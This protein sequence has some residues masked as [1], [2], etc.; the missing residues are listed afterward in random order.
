MRVTITVP[1]EFDVEVTKSGYQQA[2]DGHGVEPDE[3]ESFPI[4]GVV[5]HSINGIGFENFHK[6]VNEF[7]VSI[8]ED[9]LIENGLQEK[10]DRFMNAKLMMKGEPE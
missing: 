7:V 4:D 2:F 6:A 5:I 3:D 1:I 9:H 8:F 10:Y